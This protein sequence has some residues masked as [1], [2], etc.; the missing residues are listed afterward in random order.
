MINIG[1]KMISSRLGLVG[2]LMLMILFMPFK[3][4]A[5][6][7]VADVVSEIPAD[8]SIQAG[9]STTDLS[10][11]VITLSYSVTTT[12]S[13]VKLTGITVSD[14]GTI[15]GSDAGL[16]VYVNTKGKYTTRGA[17]LA[18]SNGYGTW[19]KGTAIPFDR[20][21]ALTQNVKAYV[22]IVYDLT[23]TAAG[24]TTKVSVTSMTVSGD[25]WSGS[26]TTANTTN[27]IAK[28]ACVDTI[29]VS[30]CGK[31]HNFNGYY[32]VYYPY[33]SVRTRGS[34]GKHGGMKKFECWRCHNSANTYFARYTATAPLHQNGI[35][36]IG[37]KIYDN[38]TTISGTWDAT[39]KTCSTV[40]CHFGV[41]TPVWG[42]V[43]NPCTV[44]HGAP[45]NTG[46]H[47]QHFTSL[48]ITANQTNY[49][50][51]CHSG[52]GAGSSLHGDGT[53]DVVIDSSLTNSLFNDINVVASYTPSGSADGTCSNV[54]CH[55]GITTYNWTSGTG[56]SYN[57]ADSKYKI[58]IASETI[59]G[60]LVPAT[61][62]KA[63]LKCTA[64]HV[65]D[66]I[67][68]GGE[69]LITRWNS[70][71]SGKHYIHAVGTS[72]DGI[73]KSYT[74]LVSGTV[75]DRKRIRVAKC[76]VC[77]ND[78]HYD[79]TAGDYRFKVTAGQYNL[80]TSDF[81]AN[82]GTAAAPNNMGGAIDGATIYTYTDGS[83]SA[84]SQLIICSMVGRRVTL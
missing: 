18:L 49:C 22:F 16:R 1:K 75:Y 53:V 51:Y 27:I 20:Q 36:D 31:C 29:Q 76:Y 9:G 14:A 6:I 56:T 57:P 25:T 24:K 19:T 46:A 40:D 83:V 23:S 34:H 35:A 39:S 43:N 26:A 81:D 74:G 73:L 63:W 12:L 2:V 8:I 82:T 80:T 4:M 44:C 54:S 64:C 11:D 78:A 77:H 79:S 47:S 28:T 60:R 13:G 69:S 62:T 84:Q 33:S 30:D 41:T 17:V 55:G 38:S 37:P 42:T 5:A 7:T 71:R 66:N 10:R 58:L 32:Q 70:A 59:S 21:V 52:A 48:G 72:A 3:V 45:P 65:V 50:Y 15:T 61:E 68:A 67:S